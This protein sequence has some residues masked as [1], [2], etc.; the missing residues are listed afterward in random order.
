MLTR[1]R[2]HE[3]LPTRLQRIEGRRQK[4]SKGAARGAA[5]KG[6]GRA[7]PPSL[8]QTVLH[9]LV[10]GPIKTG[11]RDVPPQRGSQTAPQVPDAVRPHER[12]QGAEDRSERVRR[13]GQAGR[14]LEVGPYELQGRDHGADDAPRQHARGQG[15]DGRERD[16]GGHD[17]AQE[18]VIREHVGRR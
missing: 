4:R 11:E 7:R 9:P 3:G 16:D 5:D 2:H 6:N 1:C 13:V 8:L 12:L 15:H 18:V 14:R 17:L 10:R